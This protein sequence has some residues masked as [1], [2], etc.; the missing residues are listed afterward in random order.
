[1]TTMGGRLASSA[2]FRT[3]RVCGSGPSAAST[4]RS[5]PSTSVSVRSTSEPKSA[6]PGVSTMLMWTPRYAMAV[7]LAMIVMPFSRSRSIESMMRSGTDS[8]WRKRPDCQSM[9]STRVVLPWSTW[10]MIAMLRIESRCC[11]VSSYHAT[12]GARLGGERP[13]D[14]IAVP[15]ASY[16]TLIRMGGPRCPRCDRGKGRRCHRDGALEQVLSGVYIYPFRCSL[17]GHRFRALAWGRRYVVG[18]FARG[19][20]ATVP[21]RPTLPREGR[22]RMLWSADVQL[23]VLVITVIVLSWLWLSPWFVRC[24]YGVNC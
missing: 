23:V 13:G 21:P 10:A 9:A 19:R 4:R 15:A 11:I 3:N 17:C 16:S 22:L 14:G 8:F 1:M 7:F 2:F 20:D 5:T 18:L 6:W 12:V 24:V